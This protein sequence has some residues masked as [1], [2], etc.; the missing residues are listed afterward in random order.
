MN[1]ANPQF[2]DQAITVEKYTQQLARFQSA[3]DYYRRL[4]VLLLEDS[5]PNLYF[6]FAATL[7]T[8]VP[9][10]FAV[11]INFDNYDIA[12]LSVQFVHPVTF[13]PIRCSQLPNLLLR[14]LE[15]SPVPQNLLVADRDDRPFFCIPGIREYHEHPF[16]T[17]DSWFLYRDNG[18]EGSLCFI[19]DNLQLYG[20]SNIKSYQ[21]QINL[22]AQN[23]AVGIFSDPNTFPL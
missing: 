17:G 15:N 9:I 14:K 21:F 12:P 7:L 23:N 6:G 22:A 4:G 3:R 13:E 1:E 16:H 2:V 11:K 18:N 8:P 19:L 20:T 5:F 10:I